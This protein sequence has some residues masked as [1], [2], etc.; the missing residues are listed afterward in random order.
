[1]A[2]TEPDATERAALGAALAGP[3]GSLTHAER[4]LVL[5]DL[6]QLLDMLGLGNF[7]RPESP[8]EVFQICLRKLAEHENAIT[9]ETSCLSCAR[10][11]DR[12]YAETCR[13]ER[14]EAAVTTAAATEK[15]RI[16]KVA[17]DLGAHYHGPDGRSA[18]FADYLRGAKA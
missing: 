17:D 15:E 3:D 18:P 11:L 9:W 13:A 5:A 10:V 2:D 12:S 1:M 7:A 16:A 8:H 14:A 4:D 6:G